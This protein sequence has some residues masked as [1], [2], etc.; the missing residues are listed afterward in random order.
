MAQIIRQQQPD[1]NESIQIWF[2]LIRH[3]PGVERDG[4]C[5]VLYLYAQIGIGQ[6]VLDHPGIAHIV[7]ELLIPRA[8]AEFTAEFM[9]F[10]IDVVIPD[11]LGNL[12]ENSLRDDY[13]LRKRCRQLH[14]KERYVVVMC[15]LAGTGFV[16]VVEKEYF[17]PLVATGKD[18]ER[19]A[20]R[21]SPQFVQ[22]TITPGHAPVL[23][24]HKVQAEFCRYGGHCLASFERADIAHHQHDDKDYNKANDNQRLHFSIPLI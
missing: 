12:R 1:G 22:E 19:I 17:V 3:Q 16:M 24:R 6:E 21:S 5:P 7:C 2:Y 10:E 14:D 20:A 15:I 13:K 9:R 18:I 11:G 4:Q 23:V 8:D